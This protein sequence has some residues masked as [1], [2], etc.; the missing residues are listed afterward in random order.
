[1]WLHFSECLWLESLTSR[2][3]FIFWHCTSYKYLQD[4]RSLIDY[5]QLNINVIFVNRN[6]VFATVF[7]AISSYVIITH[8]ILVSCDAYICLIGCRKQLAYSGMQRKRDI[9]FTAYMI[10]SFQ[11]PS[12]CQNSLLRLKIFAFECSKRCRHAAQHITFFYHI[13]PVL[14]ISVS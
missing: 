10:S 11:Q 9:L 13:L 3:R 7:S 8:K 2:L 5:N 14:V 12:S 1:M 6:F 4:V